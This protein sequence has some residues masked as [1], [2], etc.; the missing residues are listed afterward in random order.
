MKIRMVAAAPAETCK[1]V[2][3]VYFK[4]RDSAKHPFNCVKQQQ[5]QQQLRNRADEATGR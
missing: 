3:P 1:L 2:L 4:L 5:K